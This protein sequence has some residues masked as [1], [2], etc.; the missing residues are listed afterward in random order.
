[1]GPPVHAAQVGAAPLQ[2][3]QDAH[4]LVH[5]HAMHFQG[6]AMASPSLFT[7]R[8]LGGDARLIGPMMVAVAVAVAA[9]V[10]DTCGYLKP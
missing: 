1:M 10:L 5:N 9:A 6:P 2:A 7:G 8:L 4:L 3:S